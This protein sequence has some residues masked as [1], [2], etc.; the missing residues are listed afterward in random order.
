MLDLLLYFVLVSNVML[1]LVVADYHWK[2]NLEFSFLVL[3]FGFLIYLYLF[4]P[5][6]TFAIV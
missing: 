4:F 1:V 6:L 2:R 5:E 3:I